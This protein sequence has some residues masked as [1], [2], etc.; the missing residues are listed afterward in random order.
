MPFDGITIHALTNELKEV[1]IGSKI[2][3]IHQ[4]ESD[5]IVFIIRKDRKNIK[6]LLSADSNLP[7]FSL[8]YSK[9]ENP[10]QAPMFCMLL[11]KHL[12]GGR[13]VNIKQVGLERVILISIESK[14][15]LGEMSIK[16]I[17]FEIMGKHSNITMVDKNN[18]IID[19]I[20]RIALGVN[21]YRQLF[22]GITYLYP[23][24][25]K[26]DPR[27][28]SK[29]LFIEKFLSFETEKIFKYVYMSY[30]GIS[31]IISKEICIKA[32]V[33]FNLFTNE[34]SNNDLESL[35]ESFVEFF[36]VL[37]PTNYYKTVTYNK[38]GSLKDLSI[39]KLTP[40]QNEEYDIVEFPT[41][42]EVVTEYY[43]NKNTVNK[44]LQRSHNLRKSVQNK[45]TKLN[46]KLKNLNKDLTQADNANE[47]KIKGDLIFSNIYR[48]K[49]GDKSINVENYY[50]NNELITITLDILKTPSENAQSYFK[51]YTKLK[52]AQTKVSEQLQIATHEIEYLEQVLVNIEQ[53]LDHQNIED[54]SEELIISGYIKKKHK[55]GKPKKSKSE[56]LSYLS[57]DGF[58][59]LVGKNNLQNDQ[60]TLKIASKSDIW[61]HT[62][63]IP[64][65]HVIIRCY[66]RDVS[67][68]ALLEG[69][70]I[71]AYHSKAKD[72]SGVPVDYTEVRNV[73]KPN[74]AKPGMVIYS[75]N[76]TINTTPV[77]EK[78]LILRV[79]TNS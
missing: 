55:K 60:L 17:I 70:M 21:R 47:Y 36:K 51:K 10:K 16:K 18:K 44:L 27:D 1:L 43:A 30:Q 15:E 63:I 13:I 6:L 28:V 34:L 4:P 58:E 23:P 37:I 75:T 9:K 79:K 40:Y 26:I 46:K 35:A 11:R 25:E 48:L 57:S 61:M 71:A 38:N 14:N 74:G 8:S 66:G 39:I 45:I 50:S 54:I 19:C 68:T 59:I 31:P 69:A 49:K 5:E 76:Y 72:S 53:S 32:N 64:G 42:N 29:K 24:N 65:S 77:E 41:V 52:T 73:K 33:D 12:G 20:K 3:K 56:P 62:K 22:P 78:V 2:D 67:E 7:H